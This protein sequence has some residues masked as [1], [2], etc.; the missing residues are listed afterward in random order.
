MIDWIEPLQIADDEVE[1]LRHAFHN[2]PY[3]YCHNVVLFANRANTTEA[4]GRAGGLLI[5]SAQYWCLMHDRSGSHAG[6]GYFLRASGQMFCRRYEQALWAAERAERVATD[7][8]K[9][10]SRWTRMVA[11]ARLGRA[12]EAHELLPV[13][14]EAFRDGDVRNLMPFPRLRHEEW[15][16]EDLRKEPRLADA[17]KVIEQTEA[18]PLGGKL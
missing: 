18:L 6:A 8:T 12:D 4:L 3:E 2:A 10:T 5:E 15:V 13:I 1:Y 17:W 9:L 14:C 7:K 11:L 16:F